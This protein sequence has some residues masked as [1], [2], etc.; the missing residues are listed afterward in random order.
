MLSNEDLSLISRRIDGILSEEE[1]Q[2]FQQKYASDGAFK[3]EAIAQT[4]VLAGIEALER[5]ALKDE[6]STWLKR[7]EEAGN[8]PTTP[9]QS[10]PRVVWYFY[11][12]AAIVPF[13]LIAIFLLWPEV[14]TA[15]QLFVEN[16]QPLENIMSSRSGDT[17]QA[18]ASGM[19]YYEAQEYQSAIVEL[20]KADHEDELVK[21]Y[22][23]ISYLAVGE[24]F[25]A[26]KSLE[27]LVS[28]DNLVL[29]NYADWYLA[30]AHLK[31][32]NYELAAKLLSK[33]KDNPSSDYANDASR[34]LLDIESLK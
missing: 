27:P 2:L 22:L 6:F 28:G 30:L 31:E 29:A 5:K 1:E 18:I 20:T 24:T 7:D 14:K 3:E 19:R 8:T 21:L 11:A 9:D 16:F 34:L 10:K 33:I 15:D 32:Q 23:G 13:V 26:K 4:Q 17:A 12:A 25:E